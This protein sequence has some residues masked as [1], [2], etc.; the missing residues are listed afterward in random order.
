V[1]L[2]TP[3]APISDVAGLLALRRLDLCPWAN[4]ATFAIT[5]DVTQ[6]RTL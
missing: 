2:A 5:H 6:A 1:L 4:A 3:S